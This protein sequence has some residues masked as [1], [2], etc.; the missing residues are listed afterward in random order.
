M[1]ILF[2]MT[3]LTHNNYFTT[4]GTGTS[5]TVNLK[6]CT[7]KIIDDYH[8]ELVR[9]AKI[10][11]ESSSSPI[12]LLF[13]GGIDGE[14]MINIFRTAKIPFKVAIIS[15]NEWNMHD[16][17][18]AFEYCNN[19]TI[20]P[21]VVDIDI[22]KFIES[23]K[24]Y[25][26]ANSVNCAAYQIPSIMEGISKL[27]G[28]IILA[29]GEPYIKNFDGIWKYE[30]TERVNSY[31]RWFENNSIDGTPDFLRYTAESTFAFI[32]EP[33]VQELI[34]NKHPGKLSTR[35]SKHLIYSK[36]YNFV[37]RPKY[38]GWEEIEKTPLMSSISNGFEILKLKHN[39]VF[40]MEVSELSRILL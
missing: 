12:T 4:V 16:T 33:R 20:E 25:D 40:E 32:N 7:Q 1:E 27:D 24:I 21:I 6:S 34:N 26:I 18:Y 9:A 36:N 8:N 13:S 22:K 28:T 17:E 3:S 5:W 35:T 10:I 38:T 14:Y 30:E 31:M 19:H 15:Y 2:Q 37:P 39:G 29:N 23:G 11:Y